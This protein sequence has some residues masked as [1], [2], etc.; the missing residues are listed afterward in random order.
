MLG[1]DISKEYYNQIVRPL[2]EDYF[3]QVESG[4]A[5]ALIGWGS[6]VLSNDDEYSR[7][8]E[9]GPRCVIFL[10]DSLSKLSDDLLDLFNAKVP[11]FLMGYPTRFSVD[12]NMGV[13]VPARDG[14]GE[15]NIEIT[16]VS[17]YFSENLGVIIPNDDMDWLS[18]PENKLLEITGG[19]VFFDGSGEL[20]ALREL[21]KAYYPVNVWK[22]RLAYAWQSLGWDIDLIGLCDAR[23]DLLSSRHCLSISL[24]KIM[25]LTFLLNRRYSPSYPKWQ[26]KEFY[27]LPYLSNEI[28]PVLESCYFDRVAKSA[29]GKLE[30]VCDLL[31]EYQ[32]S[33]DELPRIDKKPCRF[34]RGFWNIDL[35][36]I[37]DQIVGT[38]TSPLREI[39]LDAGCSPQSSLGAV[40]QWVTNE[41]LMLDSNKLKTLSMIYR[42]ESD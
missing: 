11:P 41:D 25:K 34:A 35:Q 4:H 23:G 21:Y 32:N 37:A 22:Y 3:P 10:Q 20:T 6:D 7:D 19:E 17:E 1:L 26:G 12:R 33:Y 24:F 14:S 9:W 27:K 39:S 42:H 30:A 40:D 5:A 8:H 38:I 16:T 2:I 13:R 28:G 31:I 29:L 15:V 18:L 36:H